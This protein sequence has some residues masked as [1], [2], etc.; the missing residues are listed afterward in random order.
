[1]YL[2][3]FILKSQAINAYRFILKNRT[4]HVCSF[5][6]KDG[7]TNMCIEKTLTITKGETLLAKRA[8]YNQ[9]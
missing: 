9:C 6:L 3:S 4:N 5:V 7:S 2:C 1:M 8:W